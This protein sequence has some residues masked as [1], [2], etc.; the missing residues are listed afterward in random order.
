M[1]DKTF[2]NK[3]LKIVDQIGSLP[4]EK[5]ADLMKLAQE[6]RDN[7]NK[8]KTSIETLKGSL[9]SLRLSTKYMTF[10]LEATKREN[11]ALK[12]LLRDGK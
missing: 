6:T 10:D 1:D 11:E 9:D 8:I 7:H 2:N 3:F 4:K 5:R 12:K